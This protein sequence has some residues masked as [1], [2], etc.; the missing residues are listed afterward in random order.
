[1]KRLALISDIHGNFEGLAAVLADIEAQRCD[2]IL[3]LGD[4]VDGGDGD[5]ECVRFVRDSGMA[6]V[7][8]NHDDNNDVA[9]P[10]DLQE[11]LWSLPYTLI[12]EDMIFAHI[13]PRYKQNQIT[14]QYEAW[15]VFEECEARLMFVGHAHTA[16]L[17]GEKSPYSAEALPQIIV[18]NQP[19]SLDPYDRYIICAGAIGYSRDGVRMPQYCIYDRAKETIE[20]RAVEGP[21]I[22]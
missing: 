8:G 10:W 2:R 15:N 16:Q 5:V 9:L 21:L 6:C 14:D 4:I 12:E 19:I 13:S 1:M 17:Y 22:K 20:F 18:R 11:Y 3:C 7:R